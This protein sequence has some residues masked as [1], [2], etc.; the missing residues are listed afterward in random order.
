MIKL[1]V[2]ELSDSEWFS[3]LN[4]IPKKR[5]LETMRRLPQ[6]KCSDSTRWVPDSPYT[7]LYT[8]FSQLQGFFEDRL[9]VGIL[10]DTS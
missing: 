5:R 4:M 7:G 2:I 3:A 8:A 1:G 9:S 10:P 6:F